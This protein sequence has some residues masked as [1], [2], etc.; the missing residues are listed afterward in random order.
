MINRNH[1]FSG[2]LACTLFSSGSHAANIPYHFN[3]AIDS[4]VLKPNTYQGQFTYDDSTLQVVD[5][6][7][8]FVG[9]TYTEADD[10]NASV[11]FGNNIFLG[12][13]YGVNGTPSFAFVPGTTAVEEA[14]FSYDLNSSPPGPSGTG[15]VLYTPYSNLVDTPGPSAVVGAIAALGWSRRIR[16]RISSGGKP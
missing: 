1:L 15:E 4:G 12:L 13:S 9:K 10:Q 5:F 16:Q 7:F 3:V 8:N 2:L 11:I 14:Y 6:E